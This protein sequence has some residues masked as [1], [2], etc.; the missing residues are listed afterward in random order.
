MQVIS[1]MA[2]L[3]GR[4]GRFTDSAAQSVIASMPREG[5]VMRQTRRAFV[6]AAGKPLR[7]GDVLP[8]IYPQLDRFKHWHRWSARRALLSYAVPIGRS[9]TGRGLPVI[10]APRP[11]GKTPTNS[12]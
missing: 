1:S 9:E 5:R 8:W 11:Y 12:R 4:R 3:K 2:G 10:W 7:I 6:A